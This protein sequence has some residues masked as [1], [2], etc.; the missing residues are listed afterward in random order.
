MNLDIVPPTVWIYNQ[1]K[2]FL[3]QM[4]SRHNWLVFLEP[5]DI[6]VCLQLVQTWTPDLQNTKEW[7]QIDLFPL[8]KLPRQNQGYS[9]DLL[10]DKSAIVHLL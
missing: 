3:E 6:T 8:N 1:L 5:F 2:V 9:F 10:W 7:K 4:V